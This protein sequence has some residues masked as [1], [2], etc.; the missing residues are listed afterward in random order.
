MYKN[1]IHKTLLKNP[2]SPISQKNPKSPMSQ[3]WPVTF[4]YHPLPPRAPFL[5]DGKMKI[6][7][8]NMPLDAKKQTIQTMGS[9]LFRGY[10]FRFSIPEGPSPTKDAWWWC[11]RH[12]L[13]VLFSYIYDNDDGD[14]RLWTRDE[15]R[16]LFRKRT[17]CAVIVQMPTTN[18]TR[19]MT[20]HNNN[21]HSLLIATVLMSSTILQ[22][23]FSFGYCFTF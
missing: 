2:K 22:N 13:D 4:A 18:S 3:Q 23:L 8:A 1:I 16:S 14:M 12:R 17:S 19:K 20:R 10:I 5:N 6:T 11:W 21:K 15:R 9:L 7:N